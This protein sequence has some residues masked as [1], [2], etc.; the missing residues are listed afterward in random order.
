MMAPDEP[1]AQVRAH[2][3][4]PPTRI[5]P[6]RGVDERGHQEGAEV[7][8]L[9]YGVSHVRPDHRR[10]EGDE[11]EAQQLQH[12]E[13]QQASVE[14]PHVLEYPVVALPEDGDSCEA[15]EEAEHFGPGV[16]DALE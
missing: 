16:K 4:A 10:R 11:G 6:Q 14:A 15:G 7:E 12:L 5:L 1:Q 9:G 8:L 13:P 2:Q 3:P